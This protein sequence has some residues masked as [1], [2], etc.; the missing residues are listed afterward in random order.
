MNLIKLGD[1]MQYWL[2]KSE[3]NTWSWSNQVDKGDKG[4][5]WDG[6]KKLSSSK[7]HEIYENRRSRFFLPLCQ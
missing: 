1:L 6:V 2:F 7:K 5:H 4:E 3:P